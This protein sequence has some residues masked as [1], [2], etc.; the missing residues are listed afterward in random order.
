MDNNNSTMSTLNESSSSLNEDNAFRKRIGMK[1]PLSQILKEEEEIKSCTRPK[2]YQSKGEGKEKLSEALATGAESPTDR[3]IKGEKQN[4]ANA[5][6]NDRVEDNY[7]VFDNSDDIKFIQGVRKRSRRM[8]LSFESMNT[9]TNSGLDNPELFHVENSKQF[10]ESFEK[11]KVQ[12][13]RVDEELRKQMQ[14]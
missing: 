11:E 14:K 5:A 3:E 2:N 8:C 9:Y 12:K 13:E 1:W 10:D 4:E 7:R 6:S